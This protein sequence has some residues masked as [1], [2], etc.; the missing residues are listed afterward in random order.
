MRGTTIDVSSPKIMGVLNVTPDSFSD[1]GQYRGAAD[2][3]DAGMAMVESGADIVDVGGESTR[4]GADAVSAGEE[5]ARTEPIVESLASSGATVSIDTS[6]PAVAERAIA[7]GAHILNDVTGFRDPDMVALAAESGVGVVVMHM[8]GTPRTMQKDPVYADVVGEVAA[9]LQERTAALYDA[10]VDH[11]AIAI[12]PGIGF[13]KTYDHNLAL[14]EAIPTFVASG[15]P[16]VIG[17][18]RKRFLDTIVAPVVGETEAHQRDIATMAATAIAIERGAQIHR[19]HNTRFGV[20]V[21]QVVDAMVRFGQR[22][23]GA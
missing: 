22:K 8:Q 4:P 6:K 18:S 14:L 15:Y 2:A 17:L 19:V 3:A 9:Y 16:V 23:H 12:D 20:E 21:A 11:G 1:G 13:G 10:G 5:I 7:A